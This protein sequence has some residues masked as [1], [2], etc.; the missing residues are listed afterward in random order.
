ETN[1]SYALSEEAKVNLVIVDLLG[2]ELRQLINNEVR[3]EGSYIVKWDGT[4]DNGFSLS[5]GVYFV[6]MKAKGTVDMQ[7]MVLFR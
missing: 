4:N 7:K 6:V 5:S 1:I 3:S 2:R